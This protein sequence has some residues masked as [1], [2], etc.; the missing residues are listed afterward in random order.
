MEKLLEDLKTQLQLL[1]F[2]RQKSDGIIV[3]GN[4]EGVERQLQSLRSIATRVEEFKLQIEQEKI[5]KG[6]KLDEV[7]QWSVT[8]EAEQT[9]ADE[10]VAYLR[11]WLTEYK[12]R[13]SLS[14]KVGQQA[15]LE[16]SRKDQLEFERTQLEMRLAYEGK[17]R[18]DKSGKP[19]EGHGTDISS[20]RED[21]QTS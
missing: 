16:Q 11:K 14:E 17:N 19:C 2:T 6:E 12:Q 1:N 15:F 8:I 7:S 18:E 20:N 4:V 10:N 21:R 3:K 9:S 5:A 13:E